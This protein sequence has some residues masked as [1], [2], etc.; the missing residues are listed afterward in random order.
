MRPARRPHLR[1]LGRRIEVVASVGHAEAALQQERDV[2]GRIAQILRD[3]ETEEVV[4]VEVGRIEGI[5][6]RAQGRS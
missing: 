5:D 4:G 3:P 6:V 2:L 1:H